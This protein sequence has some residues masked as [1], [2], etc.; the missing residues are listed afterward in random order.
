MPGVSWTNAAARDAVVPALVSAW[1]PIGEGD[2][3]GRKAEDLRKTRAKDAVAELEPCIVLGSFTLRALTCTN[4]SYSNPP[5]STRSRRLIARFSIEEG[6]E[7]RNE[8]DE[9]E[10]RAREGEDL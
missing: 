1:R 6:D 9:D 5:L 3:A 8:N 4:P 7:K 2:R 10:S